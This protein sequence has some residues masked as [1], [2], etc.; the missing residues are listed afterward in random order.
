MLDPNLETTIDTTLG[1]TLLSFGMFSY[2]N[3]D[4]KL[5]PL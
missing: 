5:S 2:I 1:V 3:I 4:K